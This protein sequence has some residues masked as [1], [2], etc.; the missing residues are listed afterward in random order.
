MSIYI[1]FFKIPA[2]IPFIDLANHQHTSGQPGSIYFD[3]TNNAV[4]LQVHSQIE[5]G[6]EI[7]IHYG[8]RTNRHFLLHN[9]FIPE[10]INPDDNYEMK[11][12]LPVADP[13]LNLQKMKYL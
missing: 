13:E 8:T 6:Q 4:H 1:L 10:G 12:T 9:G 7:L 3:V 5:S 11:M 2:L